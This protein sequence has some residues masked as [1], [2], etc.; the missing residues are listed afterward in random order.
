MVPQKAYMHR[1][2]ASLLSVSHVSKVVPWGVNP[3]LALEPDSR[4]DPMVSPSMTQLA[5]NADSAPFV[6]GVPKE[7][8]F[9]SKV[10][11]RF[12]PLSSLGSPPAADLVSFSG[13]MFV[14]PHTYHA[15]WES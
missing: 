6:K 7:P 1:D 10:Q 2:R 3:Q 13:C 9:G 15:S 11:F 8:S 5:E 14:Y 4:I 12:C